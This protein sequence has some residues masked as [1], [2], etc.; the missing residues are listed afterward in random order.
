MT[1]EGQRDVINLL[2]CAWAGSQKYGALVWSFGDENY[3]ILKRYL[4]LRKHMKPYIM[5]LM[6]ATHEKG[7]P[8]MRPLFYDVPLDM[9]SWDIEDEYM[10][11]PDVLVAP[12]LYTGKTERKV[13]LP[14]GKYGWEKLKNS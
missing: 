12:V 9:E 10:F 13:Y 2:R 7:T 14:E 6:K 8:V 4:E 11:G 1:K 5:E 3:S